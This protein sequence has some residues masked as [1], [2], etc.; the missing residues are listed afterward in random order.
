MNFYEKKCDQNDSLVIWHENTATPKHFHHNLEII[1]LKEG[2]L[3]SSYCDIDFVLEPNE[4]FVV[5]SFSSHS[6]IPDPDAAFIAT[7]IPDFLIPEFQDLFRTKNFNYLLTDCE[8]NKKMILPIL[9][10]FAQNQD[11]D[12]P[13]EITNNWENKFVQKGCVDILLGKLISHYPLTEIKKSNFDNT[14]ISVLQY[15]DMNYTKNISLSIIANAVG[16]NKYYISKLFNSNLGQNLKTYINNLRLQKLLN[17]QHDPL[18]NYRPF[19]ELLKECG[20]S[21]ISAYYRCVNRST[22]PTPPN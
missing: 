22:K 3:N 20:F 4:I 1:Y 15:I 16:Y 17:M 18:E 2:L 21:D 5:H 9:T 10:E 14:L 8:F 11:P 7:I 19:S 6:I 12:R 13:T